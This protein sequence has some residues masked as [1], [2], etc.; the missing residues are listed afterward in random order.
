MAPAKFITVVASVNLAGEWVTNVFNLRHVAR[1]QPFRFKRK[2]GKQQVDVAAHLLRA[3][4]T[5]R[6]NLRTD[7]VNNAQTA[8]MQ[9]LSET[10]I[11]FRPIDENYCGRAL[12]DSQLF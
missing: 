3:I 5:P 10:Q 12:L 4:R 11:E 8:A 9:C 6:P 2:N 7:V 1:G